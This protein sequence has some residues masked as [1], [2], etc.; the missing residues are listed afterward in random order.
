MADRIEV[1]LSRQDRE[2]LKRIANSLE[3]LSSDK[4]VD[5]VLRQ[6]GV[7]SSQIDDGRE[8]VKRFVEGAPYWGDEPEAKPLLPKGVTGKMARE[9]AQ[10]IERIGRIRDALQAY[11]EANPV[12]APYDLW[13]AERGSPE[14]D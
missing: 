13:S 10:S 1:S 8:A 11:E 4:F 2:L 3:A 12:R 6:S 5:R 14:T 9:Q 7:D